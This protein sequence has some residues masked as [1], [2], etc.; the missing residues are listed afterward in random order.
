M[1]KHPWLGVILALA[2]SFVLWHE[3]LAEQRFP[4]PEFETGHQLP[5]VAQPPP[6]ADWRE[7]MDV[8]VLAVALC[9]AAWVVLWKRNR[10]GM[11]VLSLFSL[12]Y[13]GFY[14]KGCVCPIGSIQDVT[15]SLSN[16]RYSVL[17]GL[18]NATGAAG[19]LRYPLP[20][21]VVLFFALPLV[22]ALFFGRVFC[23]GVCPLGAAQDVV[24]VR[25][26]RVPGW[27]VQMLGVLPFV[28]LGLAV[29]FA[30]TDTMF[31]ICRY[32]PFVSFF[33]LSGSFPMLVAGGVVLLL[34]TFIGRPYCRFLCPYGALL[35]ICSRSA[36][37]H[38]TLTPDDCVVCS[39]CEDAC[40]FDAIRAPTPEG[41]S[42]KR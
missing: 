19:V 11:V 34:A 4:P 5:S 32:D 36:W 6:R 27:L 33:R 13:F 21:T 29:L 12:A 37:R 24:L 42:E 15:L 22:F 1:M 25:P 17:G 39:L 31:I 10:R 7:I 2:V 18:Q 38:A 28:Y 9:L 3:A 41:V 14:R 8:T 23:G 20:F 16:M 26:V 30:A 40:P 35:G